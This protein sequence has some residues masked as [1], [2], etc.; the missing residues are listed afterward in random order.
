MVT[1]SS[2]SRVAKAL[3]LGQ[4]EESDW[5]LENAEPELCVHFLS[6]PS[7]QNYS[8]LRQRLMSANGRW[9]Q[10]FL[11][12]NG[13]DMLLEALSRLTVRNGV[14]IGIYDA[15]TQLECVGCVRA[16]LNSQEGLEHL[17]CRKKDTRR[18][19]L[20]LDTTNELVKRQV[21]ELFSALCVF[22]NEGHA[23]TLDALDHYKVSRNQHSRF[24]VVLSELK[25]DQVVQ[26]Q[27][28]LLGF[29]NAVILGTNSLKG[30]LQIRNE[31]FALDLLECL[32]TL[33]HEDNEDILIQ[34]DTFT[35]CKEEDELE[36]VQ[37]YGETDFYSHEQLF[38]AIFDKVK[39]SPIAA[40]LLSILQNFYELESHLPGSANFWNALDLLSQRAAILAS[41]DLEEDDVEVLCWRL[42]PQVTQGIPVP[43]TPPPLPGISALPASPPLS[44]TAAPATTPPLPGIPAPP[45]PP[46][47]P[48]IPALPAPPPLPGIPAPATPP[49]LP[50]I[51]APPASPPLSGTAAP[52]TPPHLPG[53]P[54]PATP[55]PLPG[56]PAPPPLPQIPAPPPPPPLPGIPAPPPPPPLSGIPAP[57]P[58]PQIP[59]PPPPPPPLP[60]IPAPPPLPQIPAPPPPPPPLPGIPA[61][62]PPPPLP[63][64]PA[65]PLLEGLVRPVQFN[66]LGAIAGH[67][68]NEKRLSCH[69]PSRKMKKLNWKKLPNHPLT[70]GSS[71]WLSGELDLPEPDFSAIEEF[72]SQVE[73]PSKKSSTPVNKVEPQEISFLD[74]QKSLRL[75]IFLK[76]FKCSNDEIIEMIRRG[77]KEKLDEEKLKQ[78]LKLLPEEDEIEMLKSVDEGKKL[79]NAESFYQ[80]LI[81]LPSYTVRLE[82]LLLCSEANSIL[83]K[84]RPQVDSILLACCDLLNSTRLQRF[85]MLVLEVGNFLNFGNYMGGASGFHVS[86]LSKLKQVRGNKPGVSLLHFLIMESKD[87]YADLLKLPDDLLSISKAANCDIGVITSE[88]ARLHKRIEDM[89]KATV[90]DPDVEEQFSHDI[91]GF[92]NTSSKLHSTLSEIE[93]K[94]LEIAAYICED[95]GKF[96]LQECIC[97]ISSFSRDFIQA[98]QE[99]KA[100]AEHEA[101]MARRREQ[102]KAKMA[103]GQT[104]SDTTNGAGEK[105]SSHC[106]VDELLAKL[107]TGYKSNAKNRPRRGARVRQRPSQHG[108]VGRFAH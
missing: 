84:L 13:L 66:S 79:G 89:R 63:G 40:T 32:N 23:L 96:S 82:A 54:A 86:T 19:F 105:H 104:D 11:D 93:S 2:W 76:Q 25:T 35:D 12:L 77:D 49:P 88:A 56:I 9:M 29:L 83:A 7:S 41:E 73:P 16:I 26:Y 39:N 68:S 17:V 27:D 28:T 90:S 92:R 58:L 75:N 61:P 103:Q 30:R 46:H 107:K 31:L 36:L 44:G 6:I 21:F 15:Y 50:C 60:G 51:P 71:L 53:I 33:R 59:A 69:Q 70:A 65:P 24:S 45:T 101:R 20:A 99:N 10:K 55:P 37:I 81:T 72:F 18:L 62:P 48:G 91:E 1:H 67:M 42:L 14:G 108:L 34:C 74:S 57:P 64:I 8:G 87:K 52:T 80:H 106:M 78:L 4:H 100:R 97:N 5:S 3:S 38:S 43:A 47:L 85:C 94:R 22:S 98:E 102:E 95:E